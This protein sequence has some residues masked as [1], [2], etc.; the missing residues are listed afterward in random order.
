MR[1][2]HVAAIIQARMGSSRFPG[3]MMATLSG[4]PLMEWV[5]RRSLAC[6]RVDEVVLATTE[7]PR[8]AVLAETAERLGVR[9]FRGD[10][11]DVLGRYA[12]AAESADADT[13]VRICADRPLVDPDVVD[14]AIDTFGRRDCDLAF[15]HIADLGENWPRG[16]GA[17][18]LGAD[19]LHWMDKNTTEQ[20]HREHV[21]LYVWDHRDRYRLATPPCPPAIDP[22]Y[23]GVALDVDW[24]EDL[25]RLTELCAGL[26]PEAGAPEIMARWK[27]TQIVP[28]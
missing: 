17:E 27:S 8:D 6:R 16:F 24:P 1:L 18:V 22:G 12:G 2:G 11:A 4:V 3:K 28:G 7:C 9:V 25:V 26:G 19:L 14:L 15:N 5:L 20:P 10:E 21:T 13:V 23:P